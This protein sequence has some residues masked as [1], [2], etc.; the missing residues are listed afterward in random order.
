MYQDLILQL[1]LAIAQLEDVE[2]KLDEEAFTSPLVVELG[3][4]YHHL[5]MTITR[6]KDKQKDLELE[7]KGLIS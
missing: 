4:C 6:L 7:A 5:Q 1:E 3:Y 2:E